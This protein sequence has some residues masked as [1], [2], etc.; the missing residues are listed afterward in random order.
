MLTVVVQAQRLA[1]GG[2]PQDLEMGNVRTPDR[3][4]SPTTGTNG[5]G[6]PPAGNGTDAMSAFYAEV[7]ERAAPPHVSSC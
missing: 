2:A 7:R 5:S 6:Y 1:Q 4:T 3:I